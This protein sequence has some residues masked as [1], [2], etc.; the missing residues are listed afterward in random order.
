MITWNARRKCPIF[1]HYLKAPVARTKPNM[2]GTLTGASPDT[3]RTLPVA[4]LIADKR[5]YGECPA[6][7][8][9]GYGDVRGQ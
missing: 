2:G 6:S 9:R 3:R 8:R 4:P 5:C 7:V 1:E